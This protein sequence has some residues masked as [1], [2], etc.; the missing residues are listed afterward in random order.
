MLNTV[1]EWW[2]WYANSGFGQAKLS[3]SLVELT[4]L[5]VVLTFCLLFRFARIG[6]LAA[7]LFI[8]R[9]GWIFCKQDF[10]DNPNI[11]NLFTTAYIIFGIMVFSFA[12]AGMACQ[13]GSDE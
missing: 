6:L 8:Y 5:L 1:H 4:L 7:Y 10:F 11:Q 9:W 13:K 12:I 3:I 2:L